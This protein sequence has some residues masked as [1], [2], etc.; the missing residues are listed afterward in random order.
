MLVALVGLRTAATS[1]GLALRKAGREI[2]VVGHDPDRE[3]SARAKRLG[4]VDR[5][6]G[7]AVR[8]CEQADV[9]VIDLPPAGVRQALEVLAGTLPEGA[10]VLALGDVLAPLLEQARVLLADSRGFVSGH[11]VAPAL[12]EGASEP[13]T[14]NLVNAC[15]LLAPLQGTATEALDRAAGLAEAVGAEVRFTSAAEHDGV[16]AVGSQ[17][18]IAAAWALW[19]VAMTPAGWRDRKYALG[20]AYAAATYLLEG[21]RDGWAETMVA[22]AEPLAL[23]LGELAGALDELRER[24]LEGDVEGVEALM[25]ASA[26]ARERWLAGD[27]ESRQTEIPAITWRDILLGGLGRRRGR[28]E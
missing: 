10:L 25:A 8:A 27:S 5:L 23:W 21:D 19:R 6:D 1:I 17:L 16:A 18:P 13:A 22:N 24:L 11:L 3:R 15:F 2:A 7:D 14:A 28:R 12:L 9:V 20:G 26:D 4:A